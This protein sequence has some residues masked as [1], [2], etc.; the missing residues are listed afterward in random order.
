MVDWEEYPLGDDY[1][2]FMMTDKEFRKYKKEKM[3]DF[4]KIIKPATI[5]IKGLRK[6]KA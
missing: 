5:N 3:P 4:R 1:L 6:P 2:H